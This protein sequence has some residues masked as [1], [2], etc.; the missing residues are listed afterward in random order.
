MYWTNFSERTCLYL[1]I[2]SHYM[3]TFGLLFRNQSTYCRPKKWDSMLVLICAILI[4]FFFYNWSYKS[5]VTAQMHQ[6]VV[7]WKGSAL[8][9]GGARG[10]AL[11][12]SGLGLIWCALVLPGRPC[13][14]REGTPGGEEQDQGIFVCPCHQAG[15]AVGSWEPCVQAVSK[16][17]ARASEN[18]PAFAARYLTGRVRS[19]S[20]HWEEKLSF[21]MPWPALP[22]NGGCLLLWPSF[23]PRCWHK[24]GV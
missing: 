16:H 13:P 19:V 21:A 17:L 1:C 10:G 2:F 4:P 24:G 20:D 18:E 22:F 23:V 15:N 6:T 3:R 5:H 8:D 9:L 11:G 7:F 12:S 14:R